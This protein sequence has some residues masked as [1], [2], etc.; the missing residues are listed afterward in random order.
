[1]RYG[2]QPTNL[3]ERFAFLANKVPLPILDVLV[4][5]LQAQALIAAVRAGVFRLLGRDQLS[6]AELARRAAVDAECLG[7]VLRLVASLGYLERRGDGY[8]LSPRGLRYFGPDAP[9]PYSDYVAYGP[10][11]W[12]MIGRTFDVLRSG[13]GIDF[14]ES[15]SAEEWTLYQ[16]AMAENAAAFSWFVVD[17]CPVPPGATRCLDVAGSHGLVGAALARRHPPLRS[18]VLERKEALPAARRLA[19]AHD[20]L[21]VVSYREGDLL[22]DALGAG[23]T[24]VVLLCN[25][26]HH[27]PAPQNRDIL[28]RVHDAL[29]PGGTVAIFDLETSAAD[30]APEAAG[31]AMGLYFRIT[32]TSTC[33][34]GED[35]EG[36]LRAGGFRAVRTIRSVKMPSR[37]LVVA[38]R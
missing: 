14:H 33:F 4:G 9:E 16:R 24:D 31:D 32:S 10:A 12:D 28:S 15:G 13:Q 6:V 7:L 27:F 17:N 30:A 2:A 37:M 20:I 11:Q 1:M 19:E 38:M 34:R 26:L 18:V 25:I 29:R 35:Y 36:W 23:D 5:P 21:D 3:L 8:A 22:T